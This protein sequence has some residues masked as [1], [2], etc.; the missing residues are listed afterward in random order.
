M[1]QLLHAAKRCNFT[2]CLL[3]F[4]VL[5]TVVQSIL[6]I[7]E[8]LRTGWVIPRFMPFAYFVILLAYVGRKE[9]ERW[10]QGSNGQR[11]R[12]MIFFAWWTLLLLMFIAE[13]I[14]PD[15]Y[16]HPA[17]II[18]SCLYVTAV[19]IFGDLSKRL[20]DHIHRGNHH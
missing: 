13:G 10:T 11:R 17:R 12:E 15:R 8:F 5:W 1:M 19:F 20:H 2:K 16:A 7:A 6:G 14:S 4:T 18:D 9:F 3:A